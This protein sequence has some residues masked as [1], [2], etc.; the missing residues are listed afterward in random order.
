MLEK[1]S[2]D[3]IQEKLSVPILVEEILDSDGSISPDLRYALHEVISEFHPDAALLCIASTVMILGQ[4]QGYKTNSFKIVLLE[5]ERILNDYAALW[6]EHSE[7]GSSSVFNSAENLEKKQELF[8]AIIS[9]PE[10]LECIA[11]L[12]AVN[13]G[14]V[15]NTDAK[16]AEILDILHM[17]A[18]AHAIIAEQFV[19]AI[20]EQ[21]FF[22]NAKEKSEDSFI[23]DQENENIILGADNA[24]IGVFGLHEKKENI[25]EF[26][27]VQDVSSDN[28]EAFNDNVIPFPGRSKRTELPH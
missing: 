17:Q 26:F 27:S 2:F 22:T 16:L 25:S 5:C 12:I 7:G 10:D 19:A 8:E 15:R 24:N 23:V 28:W 1:R 4:Y 18:G 6:L 21:V 11:E 14:F 3:V 9:I 20:D 13:V